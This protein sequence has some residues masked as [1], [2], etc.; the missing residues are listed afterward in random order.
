LIDIPVQNA[1]ADD[2][3][4]YKAHATPLRE[5]PA[6]K[7]YM[8]M[9]G[10]RGGRSLLSPESRR[11]AAAIDEEFAA[12]LEADAMELGFRAVHQPKKRQAAVGPLPAQDTN[13]KV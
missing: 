4:A 5:G 10:E 6:P 8:Y 7:K 9:P 11:T 1:E 13:H 2:G 3:S 12:A